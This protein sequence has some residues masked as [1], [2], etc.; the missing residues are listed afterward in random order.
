MRTA[1]PQSGPLAGLLLF[2]LAVTSPLRAGDDPAG[3]LLRTL[4]S[5]DTS[6]QEWQAAADSFQQLPADVAIRGLYPEIAKGIPNGEPYASYNCSDPHRDRRVGAWGPFCVV[7][8]LWCRAV[9]CSKTRPRIG[10]TLLELWAHPQSA[11]GQSVLLSALDSYAWVPEAEEL[12]HALFVDSEAGS[13]LRIQAAA[14]LLDHFGMKYHREVVSFASFGP[15]A[16]RNL[17]F[18]QLASAPHARHSGVD[19]AVVRLGFWLL[20]EEMTLHEDRFAHRTVGNS[21]YG[22]FL[23]ANLLGTYLGQPFTTD[24]KLPKYR[25]GEEGKEIWYRETAENAF[26]WWL[27]NRDRYAN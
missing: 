11:Y 2:C 7:N 20:L 6:D 22:E 24:Y 10:K 16:T 17:L 23:V 4:L 18:R 27:T 25:N 15:P 21:Y 9:A 3:Q 12:V 1:L 8:W 14:C 5:P 19:P 26:N 13:G